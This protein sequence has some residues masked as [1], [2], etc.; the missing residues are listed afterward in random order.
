MFKHRPMTKISPWKWHRTRQPCRQLRGLRIYQNEKGRPTVYFDSKGDR[1]FGVS[2]TYNHCMAPISS[3]KIS[4][5][6]E[7]DQ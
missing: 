1:K 3:F 7:N 5:E 2:V 6:H 4:W